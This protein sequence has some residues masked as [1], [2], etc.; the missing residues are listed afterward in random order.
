[1]AQ[2]FTLI[3][4]VNMYY[5]ILIISDWIDLQFYTISKVD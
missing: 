4:S 3:Q 2:P 1:M 5:L